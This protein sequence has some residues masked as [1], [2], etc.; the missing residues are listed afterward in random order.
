VGN[1]RKEVSVAIVD[2][3]NYV[4]E[5]YRELNLLFES[6]HRT[7][8]HRG[9][10]YSKQ[11]P[12][13]RTSGDADQIEW[14][15]RRFLSQSYC[16][17]PARRE[18]SDQNPTRFLEVMARLRSARSGFNPELH[19]ALIEFREPAK[20]AQPYGWLHD[21]FFHEAFSKFS[22]ARAG[23]VYELQDGVGNW[24][25]VKRIVGFCLDLT[26]MDSAEVVEECVSKP[27]IK[28]WEND[29]PSVEKLLESRPE[30][31]VFNPRDVS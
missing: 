24:P 28:L 7:L 12:F 31:V 20:E 9:F 26:A 8:A 13:S 5:L 11:D 25:K 19:G 17:D 14:W 16:E 27:L 3:Q 21:L 29:V 2:A 23:R 6:V 4:T 22:K 1:P 15:L 30:A 18:N 10:V